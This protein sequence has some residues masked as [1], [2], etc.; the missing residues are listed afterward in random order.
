MY[1]SLSGPAFSINRAAAR[2]SAWDV[3]RPAPPD[4][5]HTMRAGLLALTL[6]MT[7]VLTAHAADVVVSACGAVVAAGDHSSLAA[8][9]NCSAAPADQPAVV[10]KQRAS[11]SLGGF[12]LTGASDGIAVRCARHCAVTGPG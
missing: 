6:S 8:D 9:L 3:S 10:L 4:W 1:R 7:H 12:T 5:R 2:T 11:L